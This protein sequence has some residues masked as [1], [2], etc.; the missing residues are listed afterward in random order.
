MAMSFIGQDVPCIVKIF[1]VKQ[2]QVEKEQQPSRSHIWAIEMEKVKTN[3]SNYQKLI[4]NGLNSL[5]HS[6]FDEDR[7]YFRN[8]YIKRYPEETRF[9]DEYLRMRFCL[10]QH[11][12]FT[13]ETHGNNI[14]YN[15]NGDL[16]LF[17]LGQS[18]RLNKEGE[19]YE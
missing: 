12:I 2:V 7:N 5:S 17:D 9:I 4:A 6:T 18:K 11:N 10:I 15:S 8:L 14:G 1:S 16:V 13:Y 19:E 3:L